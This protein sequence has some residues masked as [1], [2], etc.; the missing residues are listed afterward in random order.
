M[1]D[2]S[3]SQTETGANKWLGYAEGAFSVV[4]ALAPIAEIADPALAPA[5]DLGTKVVQGFLAGEPVAVSLY[6]RITNPASADPSADEMKAF[7]SYEASYE[8]LRD[9]IKKKLASEPTA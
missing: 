5:I 2:L 8:A 9:D 1:S 3:T 4:K 7:A 6:N